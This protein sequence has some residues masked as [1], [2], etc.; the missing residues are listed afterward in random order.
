MTLGELIKQVEHLKK[1]E[2]MPHDV[3]DCELAIAGECVY[4]LE[5]IKIRWDR[6]FSCFYLDFREVI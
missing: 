6:G 4:P 3:L 1:I 2:G 5:L